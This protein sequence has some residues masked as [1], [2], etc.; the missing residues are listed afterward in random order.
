MRILDED[1]DKK[2]DNVLIMLTIEEARELISYFNQLINKQTPSCDH[3]HISSVDYQKEIT[4]CIYEDNR[5]NS[6][7]ERV[8]KLITSD[9]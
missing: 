3:F 8:N 1:T 2:L 7:S 6:F 4:V 9:E 5:P